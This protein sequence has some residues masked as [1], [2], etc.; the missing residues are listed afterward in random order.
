MCALRSFI[1]FYLH[2]VALSFFLR[3]SS[4]EEKFSFVFLLIMVR[5][6]S[7]VS[8]CQ[9]QQKKLA[10]VQSLEINS[11]KNDPTSSSEILHVVRQALLNAAEELISQQ[12]DIDKK[13]LNTR[14][15]IGK[16]NLNKSSCQRN[17]NALKKKKIIRKSKKVLKK[18][19][20]K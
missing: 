3:A 2:V 20:C 18:N 14:R 4:L 7:K 17:L 8:N 13:S 1:I 10:S 5:I 6:S 12:R 9:I 11:N 16:N 19:R 15:S